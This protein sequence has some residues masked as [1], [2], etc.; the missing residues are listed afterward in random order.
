MTTIPLTIFKLYIN[1][2]AK[3]KRADKTPAKRL[4]GHSKAI[5]FYGV[6]P[7]WGDTTEIKQS[8]IS[9]GYVLSVTHTFMR[10]L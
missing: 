1:A 2:K 8:G 3:S 9:L 10:S 6:K 5:S 7:V 4:I